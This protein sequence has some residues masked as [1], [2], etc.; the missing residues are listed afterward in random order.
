MRAPCPLVQVGPLPELRGLLPPE[1][2]SGQTLL[3]GAAASE[4]AS[5]VTLQ[6]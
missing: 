2:P 1:T 4:W 6:L 5:S 3:G